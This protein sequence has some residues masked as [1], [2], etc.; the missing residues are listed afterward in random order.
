MYNVIKC[1]RYMAEHGGEWNWDIEFGTG[2]WMCKFFGR[3]ARSRPDLEFNQNE[4]REFLK[5]IDE[6][7][8][9]R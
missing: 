2:V 1:L 4:L 7:E 6:T 9:W 3:G 8:A 5:Y